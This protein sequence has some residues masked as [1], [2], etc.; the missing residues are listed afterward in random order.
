[1]CEKAAA[2]SMYFA[3][4]PITRPS[5]TSQSSLVEPRG[6]STGSFGPQIEVMAFRKMIGSLGIGEPTSAAWSL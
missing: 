1:M 4:L 2:S 3:R 6:F 5:S